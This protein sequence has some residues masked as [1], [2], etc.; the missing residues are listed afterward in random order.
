MLSTLP[1][2]QDRV[3]QEAA[4]AGDVV[5]LAPLQIRAD[6]T[7]KRGWT[8]WSPHTDALRT[9]RKLKA[10]FRAGLRAEARRSLR[11]RSVV[12]LWGAKR[13]RGPEGWRSRCS[14]GSAHVVRL[15]FEA[16]GQSAVG[17]S[18]S[19]LWAGSPRRRAGRCWSPTVWEARPVRSGAGR[20][21]KE[22]R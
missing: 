14:A 20:W 4:V 21:R 18:Q 1:L 10:E 7:I 11:S 2:P 12:T 8:R 19:P 13:G 15:D 16:G 3:D 22:C 17:D 5:L 6:S 9:T